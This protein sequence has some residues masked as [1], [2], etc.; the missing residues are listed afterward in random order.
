MVG[1]DCTGL[2]L[3]AVYQGTGNAGLSHDGYQAKSGGGQAISSQS[4]LQP[5]DVVYF[6]YNANNGLNYIDHAGIYIG[7]GNVL[8]A[9]SEK[10][11]IR[12]EPISWYGPGG[13]HFVGAVRYWH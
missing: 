11:G 8:S 2:T 12:T 7:A 5:G 9:V 10:W 13:L 1:F 4:D 3:Y 6:D